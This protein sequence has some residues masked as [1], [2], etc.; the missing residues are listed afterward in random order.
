[1][2]SHSWRPGLSLLYLM[3]QQKIKQNDVIISFHSFRIEKGPWKKTFS[4]DKAKIIQKNNFKK[5]R[6]K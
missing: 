3:R 2:L 6:G 4:E 5:A 1:M